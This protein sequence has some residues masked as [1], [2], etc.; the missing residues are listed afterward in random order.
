MALTHK[1]AFGTTFAQT[2]VVAK[3]LLHKCLNKKERLKQTW[4][5]AV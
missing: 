3:N 1:E 4:L 5:T 2:V